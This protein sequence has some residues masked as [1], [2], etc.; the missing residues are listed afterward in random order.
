MST[1]KGQTRDLSFHWALL[2]SGVMRDGIRLLPVP[3][4]TYGAGLVTWELRK[5]HCCLFPACFAISFYTGPS[6]YKPSH[7]PS[8]L[9]PWLQT[10]C[11]ILGLVAMDSKG[12]YHLGG[13]RFSPDCMD[14]FSWFWTFILCQRG[15]VSVG[16]SSLAFHMLTGACSAGGGGRKDR[17]QEAIKCSSLIKA[18]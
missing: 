16:K 15:W 12:L 5:R 3:W 7:S 11:P 6:I 10:P 1:G 13:A 17:L 8:T 18:L 2:C 4:H 9:T 14:S